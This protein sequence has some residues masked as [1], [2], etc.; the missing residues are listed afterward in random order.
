MKKLL[1][2]GFVAA[3]LS[4]CQSNF[5]YVPIVANAPNMEMVEAQCQMLSSS[6]RTGYIAYGSQAYVTGA[7]IGNAIGNAVAADQFV[8]QCMTMNGWRRVPLPPKT[9]Q[10][11]A[12]KRSQAVAERITPQQRASFVDAAGM[13]HLAQKC[14]VP[15]PAKFK[16]HLKWMDTYA[17]KSDPAILSEG[18]A[19]G[20]ELFAVQMA[21]AGKAGTC[22]K[23][24]EIIKNA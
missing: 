15:V 6:T 22:K 3:A 1:A 9:T 24:A 11:A 8:Q 20:D 21:I 5:T 14:R 10:A 18:R 19:K 23:V 16:V 2:L 13:R 17:A 4:S 12:P 7:A